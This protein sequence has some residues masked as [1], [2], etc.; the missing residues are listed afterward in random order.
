MLRVGS[1]HN[2]NRMRAVSKHIDCYSASEVMRPR[3][4]AGP[5]PYNIMNKDKYFVY[6]SEHK[7]WM[8]NQLNKL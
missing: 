5:H 1:S 3:A 2:I 4:F 7:C 8:Q 6:D